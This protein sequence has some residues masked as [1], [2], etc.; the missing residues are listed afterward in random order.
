MNIL[1]RNLPYL[2]TG[3]V[4]TLYLAAAC[5]VLST[6]LGF[7]LGIVAATAARPFRAAVGAYVFL[8]RGV[9]VLIFMFLAY[10]TLPAIGVHINSRIAV[11]GALTIYAAAFVCEI[12]RG[13]IASV[14]RGQINAAKSLGLRWHTILFDITLPQAMKLS[15]PPLVSNAVVTVKITSYVAIVGVWELTYA[16]EEVVERTLA[17]FQIFSGVMAIYFVICYPLT[18]LAR[19]LERRLAYV[20]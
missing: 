12:V 5:I 10:Y 13:A 18:L 8:I 4:Q 3:A 14:P 9:P 15:L 19:F 11:G 6:L 7:F 16:G 17:A 2:L 1:I 20:E